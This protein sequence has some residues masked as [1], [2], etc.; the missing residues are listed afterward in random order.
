[1]EFDLITEV[2]TKRNHCIEGETSNFLKLL[3]YM[4]R[5]SW[6]IIK[7]LQGLKNVGD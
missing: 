2:K 6:V 5:H 1:M 3:A 7:D 4:L